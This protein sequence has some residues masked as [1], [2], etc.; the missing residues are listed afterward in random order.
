MN[1]IPRTVKASFLL[2]P[3]ILCEYDTQANSHPSKLRIF[4]ANK[5]PKLIKHHFLYL[6]F[7][8]KTQHAINYKYRYSDIY[9]KIYWADREN[10]RKLTSSESGSV[11]NDSHVDQEPVLLCVNAPR[12]AR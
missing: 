2:R 11:S 10:K 6:I 3:R 4:T 7:E 8:M 9:W 12:R 5:E 1:N